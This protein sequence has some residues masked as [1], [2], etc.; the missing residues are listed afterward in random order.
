MFSNLTL[1]TCPNP[2][3]YYSNPNDNFP[4]NPPLS[5]LHPSKYSQFNDYVN[6]NCQKFQK[7]AMAFE[8][9]E[10]TVV[11]E[12]KKLCKSKNYAEVYRIMKGFK[13]TKKYHQELKELWFE[14][15]Y[16][17]AQSYRR[18][19]LTPVFKYRIRKK[20]PPPLTIW[21]GEQTSYCFRKSTR[22]LL[23][24]TFSKSQYPTT[25]EKQSL[26]D[27]TELNE[28]QICNWFKNHRQRNKDVQLKR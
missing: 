11:N 24:E 13:F 25:L 17:E 16:D 15:H 1:P 8:W 10:E 19:T 7:E 18:K 28:E 14:T 12:L 4:Q 21:D 20:N 23:E 22:K 6:Y 2:S 26:V 3:L 5:S 27:Q 9:Y